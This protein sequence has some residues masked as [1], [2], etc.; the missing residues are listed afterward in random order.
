MAEEAV[1]V[2]QH[3]DLHVGNRMETNS[4]V[5]EFMVLAVQGENHHIVSDHSLKWKELYV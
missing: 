3:H 2:L 4:G 5:R 1:V